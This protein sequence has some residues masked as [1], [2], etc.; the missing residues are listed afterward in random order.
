ME[1]TINYKKISI[2]TLIIVAII[3]F[4]AISLQS[5]FATKTTTIDRKSV[6]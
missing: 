3:L 1:K 2:H 4:A 5:G 6:V